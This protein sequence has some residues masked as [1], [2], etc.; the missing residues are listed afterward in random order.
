M[1]MIIMCLLGQQDVAE[2]DLDRKFPA[3]QL[4]HL[5]LW[6][7]IAGYYMVKGGVAAKGLAKP[8]CANHHDASC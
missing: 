2:M 3:F 7:I 4:H 5:Y 1:R 6:K 8:G